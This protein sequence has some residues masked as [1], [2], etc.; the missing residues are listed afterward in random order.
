MD[1]FAVS[2][3]AGA[4]LE[5]TE[6]AGWRLPLVCGAFQFVMPLLGWLLGDWGSA[7]LPTLGRWAAFLLLAL[8]GGDMIRNALMGAGKPQ[9]PG[10]SWRILLALALATSIDALVV[11][12]GF[13]LV[14]LPVM[15][16]A[17]AAGLVTVPACA[18]G[19]LLGRLLGARL[20]FWA[21]LLG[22]AILIAMGLH[23]L[24]SPPG[25]A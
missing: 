12:A 23:I 25:V 7:W 22:G 2:L 13:A 8:V 4:E 15:D 11:G 10:T 6:R 9:S 20:G 5:D 1:A 16:L 3:C 18:L 17:V 19:V 24:I 21:E 14:R